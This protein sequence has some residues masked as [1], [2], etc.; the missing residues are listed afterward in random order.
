MPLLRYFKTQNDG[1]PFFKVIKD[2]LVPQKPMVFKEIHKDF[3]D[4]IVDFLKEWTKIK[5]AIP[6]AQNNSWPEWHAKAAAFI[7][8]RVMK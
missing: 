1:E 3:N 2:Q 5:R 7:K 4:R 6:D 8:T